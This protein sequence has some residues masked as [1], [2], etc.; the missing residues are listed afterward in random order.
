MISSVSNL[1]VE[2][3]KIDIREITLCIFTFIFIFFSMFSRVTAQSISEADSLENKIDDIFKEW[4][5]SLSPGG[6]VTIMKEGKVIFMKGYGYADIELSVPVT[7][8]TKLFLASISK[9]F[10]GYCIAKLIIE[11]KLSLDDD[12][13]KYIPE[14]FSFKKEIKIRDLV[15]QKSGLRDFLG[16][17][18]LTG[19]RVNDYLTNTDVLNVL[20]KQSELNF[21]TGDT[22]Q[23][24]N[25]NYFLLAEIVKRI[26]GESIRSYAEKHIFKPLNMKNTTFVDSI[27]TIIP[28]RAKS[29]HQNKDD[30]YS[31]DPF[32]DVTIGHSGLYSTAEDMSKWLIHCSDMINTGDPIFDFMIQNDTINNGEEINIYSFGLFKSSDKAL[33]YWHRGSYRGFKS[34]ITYYPEKD[35][36]IVIMGNVQTFNRRRYE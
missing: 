6:S 24:C 8:S 20:Y 22:W 11:E 25:T 16:L 23:Y 28:D 33:K 18:T 2:M 19:F 17:Y 21:M 15:F 14:M 3:Y 29:Y 9:Q 26:T 4:T 13:R 34:I 27:E 32:L 7:P 12:I 30:S 35:F 1:K 10:T 36:G 5:S 31:N